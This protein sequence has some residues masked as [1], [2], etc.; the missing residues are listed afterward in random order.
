DAL[1][2][3]LLCGLLDVPPA[4]GL[5]DELLHPAT[6]ATRAAAAAVPKPN[7]PIPKADICYLTSGLKNPNRVPASKTRR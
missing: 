1:P 2:A 7:F 5:E 4:E 6:S 3:W